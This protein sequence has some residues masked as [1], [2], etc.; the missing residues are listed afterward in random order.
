MSIT[1][2]N[3][4]LFSGLAHTLPSN[5]LANLIPQKTNNKSGEWMQAQKEVEN[6]V[7]SANQRVSYYQWQ[8][9]KL[10]LVA[11]KSN[12]TTQSGVNAVPIATGLVTTA[13][14]RDKISI[15]QRTRR[16]PA[17]SREKIFTKNTKKKRRRN[18]DKYEDKNAEDASKIK[19]KDQIPYNTFMSMIDGYARPF[20]EEN[21]QFLINKMAEAEDPK[22]YEIPPLGKCWEDAR[23]SN[24]D[25]VYQSED[26]V[27]LDALGLGK[28]SHGPLT[29]QLFSALMTESTEFDI[30]KFGNGKDKEVDRSQGESE[31]IT[32]SNPTAT[33]VL[34]ERLK[35]ELQY[36]GLLD[37]DEDLSLLNEISSFTSAAQ[38][39]KDDDEVKNRLIELQ[40]SLK[41][42]LI[43]KL[44][45][46]TRRAMQN[47]TKTSKKKKPIN[48][49][50]LESNITCRRKYTE[51]IG[52]LF[53][54][55][56]FMAPNESIFEEIEEM[57]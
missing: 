38:N 45:K 37:K 53:K 27:D 48:T 3:T 19:P 50:N 7:T 41:I 51:K 14:R 33:D 9:Q 20:Q 28:I 47:L 23:E 18:T 2:V 4:S 13:T 35:L 40:E 25:R 5:Q 1:S 34:D 42:N 29:N 31:H 46:A 44:K 22:A 57:V 24:S 39:E 36:V 6:R 10:D 21:H 12:A 52:R 56:E 49:Q 54:P 43:S 11:G 8:N 17:S 30:S 55:E 15:K 16:T 26:I 32:P